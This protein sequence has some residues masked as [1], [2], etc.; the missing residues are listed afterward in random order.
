MAIGF[1]S[2]RKLTAVR[3]RR[4]HVSI[5]FKQTRLVDLHGRLE[6]MNSYLIEVL[7]R[8]WSL[9]PVHRAEA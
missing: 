8:L 3:I 9:D 1:A 4:A 7:A 5:D 6:T 2:S